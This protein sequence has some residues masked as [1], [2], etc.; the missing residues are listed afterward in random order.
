[1]WLIAET[2]EFLGRRRMFSKPP[3]ISLESCVKRLRTI[4]LV[5]LAVLA[6]GT[7]G[8]SAVPAGP[9][10]W[11]HPDTTFWTHSSTA[12][13]NNDSTP[14]VIVAGGERNAF[15]FGCNP[16]NP[17]VHVNMVKDAIVGPTAQV[18]A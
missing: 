1:M 2:Q 15:Y 8:V 7:S 5:T 13:V 11:A 6:L 18:A 14:D 4:C 17:S 12:L 9:V 10:M 16:G 3:V